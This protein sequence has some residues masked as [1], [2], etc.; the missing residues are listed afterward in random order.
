MCFR[1]FYEITNENPDK[2]YQFLCKFFYESNYPL[3][4]EENIFLLETIK[5]LKGNVSTVDNFITAF[6]KESRLY[7]LLQNFL[8]EHK[9]DCFVNNK[10]V[11]ISALDGITLTL[12]ID[13]LNIFG[14]SNV[15]N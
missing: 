13:Y 1:P 9:F 8:P 14:Y 7:A 10:K 6:K 5:G 12:T 11:Y 4:K 3:T 15:S 2:V